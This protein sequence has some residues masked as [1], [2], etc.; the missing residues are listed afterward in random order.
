MI[1]VALFYGFGRLAHIKA[2]SAESVV[3]RKIFS[4]VYTFVL[5]LL[6]PLIYS[7]WNKDVKLDLKLMLKKAQ[8]K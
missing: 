3:K 2:S 5:S 8:F 6:N 1:I 7:L 4:I